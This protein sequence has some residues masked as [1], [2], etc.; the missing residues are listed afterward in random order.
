MSGGIVCHA[1]RVK[2]RLGKLV[3]QPQDVSP[4]SRYHKTR[5]VVVVVVVVMVAGNFVAM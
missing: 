1:A 4:T 3:F 2:H 5:A